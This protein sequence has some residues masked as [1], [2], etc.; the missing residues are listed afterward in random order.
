MKRRWLASVLIGL[1]VPALAGTGKVGLDFDRAGQ[2]VLHVTLEQL[3]QWAP[4][5]AVRVHEP[6]EARDESYLALRMRP[7]LD[8]VYGANSWEAE[9]LVFR[10]RDGYQPAVDASLFVAHEAYLA[11]ARPDGQKFRLINQLQ[12]HEDVDLAPF[13]LIWDNR[14]NEELLQRGGEGWPYQVVGVDLVRF[15]DRFPAIQPPASAS[16]MVQRGFSVFRHQCL[17]CHTL[18]GEGG[19]KGGELNSPVSVTETFSADWLRKWIANPAAV[20]SGATMPALNAEGGKSADKISEVIA[21]LQ[22][23]AHHKKKP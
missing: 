4:P 15:A 21:Y 7:I 6:H 5:Q 3:K 19:S 18:N 17:S 2:P 14:K 20:R 23:M 10:C 22:E 12:N 16:G 8:R 13:Y 1:A 9:A 11:F